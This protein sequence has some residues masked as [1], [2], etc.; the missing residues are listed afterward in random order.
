MKIDFHYYLTFILAKKAGFDQSDAST[1]AYSSQYTDDNNTRFLIDEG[2]PTQYQNYFSQTMNPLKPQKDRLRI[3]PCFHFI[4]GD[5]NSPSAKRTDDK[6]HPLNTTPDNENANLIVDEAS[7]TRDLYR[8]GI[9]AHAYVDTWAH[10]NFVGFEDNFNGFKGFP[11][12]L[13]PDIGHADAGSK[14]DIPFLIWDDARINKTISNKNRFLDAAEKLFSKFCRC[15]DPKIT[16]ADIAEKWT[17]LSTKVSNAIGKEGKRI[18]EKRM[19]EVVSGLKKI[20]NPPQYEE[21]DWFNEAIEVKEIQSF[22]KS[23]RQRH[24]VYD[25]RYFWKANYLQS[26]WYKFQEAVKA[27]QG[28]AIDI[29][30]PRF[31]SVGFS[32]LANF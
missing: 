22:A 31:E 26:R 16:E 11:A 4:P 19:E 21:K 6:R 23:Q 20:E 9:A 29:L 28:L 12:C 24:S 5:S 7:K 10:Q 17:N 8:I 3:Y 25:Y 13:I 1:I 27:H 30:N 14:P 2:K 15:I 18:L 32:N